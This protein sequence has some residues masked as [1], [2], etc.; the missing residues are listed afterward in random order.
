MLIEVR[1]IFDDYLKSR[2]QSKPEV[3]NLVLTHERKDLCLNQLCAQIR[4]AEKKIGRLMNQ[5]N[6]RAMI[7]GVANA[8]AHAVIKNKEES[9]LSANEK[10]RL[11]QQAG[12]LAESEAMIQDLDDFAMK[13]KI[14]VFQTK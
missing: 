12:T 8:Y 11:E 13:E 5:K 4:Y 6:Y 1:Q 9:I 2:L 7:E 3:L 10:K 14:Q